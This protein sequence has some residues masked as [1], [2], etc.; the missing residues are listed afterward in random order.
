M[1]HQAACISGQYS[2]ATITNTG[3]AMLTWSVI[4][5]PSSIIITPASGTLWGGR[6]QSLTVANVPY[7]T[8][9]TLLF[10][11]NGGNQSFHIYCQYPTK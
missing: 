9:V 5:N 8:D 3:Q 6:K 7:A 2:P 11:S 4:S 1:D 10:T